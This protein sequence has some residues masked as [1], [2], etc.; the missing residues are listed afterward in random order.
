MLLFNTQINPIQNKTL[1]GIKFP[2]MCKNSKEKCES[3]KNEFIV[4]KQAFDS[5]CSDDAEFVEMEPGL[6]QLFL[7]AHNKV[8]NQQANGETPGFEPAR[9][10][11]TMVN[12]LLFFFNF[13][14]QFAIYS[15]LIS[16]QTWDDELATLAMYNT[17]QCKMNH[18]TCRSTQKYQYAGQNL[19][20]HGETNNEFL[21]NWAP[22]YWF[23]EY[24]R[25]NMDDIRKQGRLRDENG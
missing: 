17:K 4:L 22:G 15:N 12:S 21:A 7:D 2:R 18:D 6:Q 5:R 3:K 1:I 11:A 14:L 25:A 16:H 10:M 20:I 23:E 24:T 8:R 9:K 19:A 13:N